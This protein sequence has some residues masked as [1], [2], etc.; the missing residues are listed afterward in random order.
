M[1]AHSP[2]PDRDVWDT[3]LKKHE[4]INPEMEAVAASRHTQIRRSTLVTAMARLAF[5][6]LVI[7]LCAWAVSTA[8][9][10]HGLERVVVEAGE[11]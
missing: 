8:W 11:Q 3:I 4:V 5:V 6:A 2:D 10:W 1:N 9:Q 7:G